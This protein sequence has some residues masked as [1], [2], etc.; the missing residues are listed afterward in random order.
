MSRKKLNFTPSVIK[1]IYRTE[2][3]S[4]MLKLS[5]PLFVRV[6]YTLSLAHAH[7]GVREQRTTS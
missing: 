4:F 5:L 3:S 7:K 2:F 1:E 6:F